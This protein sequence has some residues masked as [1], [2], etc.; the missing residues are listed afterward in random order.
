MKTYIWVLLTCIC[1]CVFVYNNKYRRNKFYQ[2]YI[3]VRFT[4]NRL[5]SFS[6]YTNIDVLP[7]NNP[8]FFFAS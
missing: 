8:L 1:R 7:Y 5:L 4:D 3:L 2:F 6:F